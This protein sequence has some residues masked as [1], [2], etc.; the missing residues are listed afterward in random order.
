MLIV[1]N[2]N[3]KSEVLES[4]SLVVVDFYADWCGPCQMLKPLLEEISEERSDVKIVKVNVDNARELAIEFGIFSIPTV[5]F[6]KEG[7]L[8]DKFVGYIG[9]EAINELI[10][11]NL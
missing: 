2:D 11:K 8:V 5:L 3:F 4:N 9:K 1:N 6:F 7:N 10:D